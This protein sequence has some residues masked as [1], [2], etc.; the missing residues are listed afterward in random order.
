MNLNPAFLGPYCLP[1]QTLIYE[2]HNGATFSTCKTVGPNY[3]RPPP[4]WRS[5]YE[6]LS[7]PTINEY[8]WNLEFGPGP[9]TPEE[10]VE[11]DKARK[12]NTKRKISVRLSQ[13]QPLMVVDV[14]GN[15][16]EEVVR[17]RELYIVGKGPCDDCYTVAPEEEGIEG[18]SRRG[19][20]RNVGMGKAC[21]QLDGQPTFVEL[22]EEADKDLLLSMKPFEAGS[23]EG[24]CYMVA[25]AEEGTEGL[26]RRIRERDSLRSGKMESMRASVVP[27]PAASDSILEVEKHREE[28][29]WWGSFL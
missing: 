9:T 1:T 15:A 10:K 25:P 21:I 28:D 27:S 4:A 24:D 19:M 13:D 22:C 5:S 8:L 2:Y 18:V 16:D 7:N 3:H 23:W 20:A 17:S 29:G 11:Y 14:C 26:R 12:D 6:H